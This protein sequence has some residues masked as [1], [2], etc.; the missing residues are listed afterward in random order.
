[1]NE[2]QLPIK[3]QTVILTQEFDNFE[4]GTR[5]TVVQVIAC[6]P[7]P[8]ASGKIVTPYNLRV[9]VEGQN[10]EDTFFHRTLPAEWCVAVPKVGDC[11]QWQINQG[12]RKCYVIAV[13]GAR[14]LVEYVMPAGRDYLLD[15]SVSNR[16][17]VGPGR[18][19]SRNRLPKF[20]QKE[21]AA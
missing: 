2:K 4:A 11:F 1:M 12:V 3:G 15:C 5:F 19:I 6:N 18:S 16:G 14:F 13:V 10:P 7:V 21:L 9:V 8:D 20:W 17:S